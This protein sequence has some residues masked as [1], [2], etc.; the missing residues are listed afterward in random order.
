MRKLD[1]VITSSLSLQAV[2]TGDVSV[3]IDRLRRESDLK[4]DYTF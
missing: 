3:K 1:A 4:K 2:L